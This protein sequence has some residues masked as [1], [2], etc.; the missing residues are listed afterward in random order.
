MTGRFSCGLRQ[1]SGRCYAYLYPRSHVL[2]ID[3][4]GASL[5][6]T[7]RLRQKH[8]CL[9]WN[10]ASAVSKTPARWEP[11]SISSSAT[12]SC[13]I[14]PIGGGPA[15]LGPRPDVERRDRH[16]GLRQYGRTGVYMLQELFRLLGLEQTADGVQAVKEAL[17][18]LSPSHPVQRYLRLAMDLNADA[19][20]VDTFLHRRDRPYTSAECLDLVSAGGLEFQ[21][22]D[23]N[24]LY[25]P[26]AHL[27]AGHPFRTRLERLQDAPCIKRWNCFTGIIPD[28]GSTP[29]GR[30]EIPAPTESSSRMRR[31]SITFR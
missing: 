10:C 5:A 8:H 18:A 31:S 25:Y 2:G 23:D 27:P 21:G 16:H 20:L 29:A 13:T 1:F 6:H 14:W 28:T 19:G 3:I 9:T 4:S 12:E 22:W 15:G 17:S 26:D 24:G 7:N 11:N 30:T